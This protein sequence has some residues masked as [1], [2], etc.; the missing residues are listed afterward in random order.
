MKGLKQ[1]ISATGDKKTLWWFSVSGKITTLKA[2]LFWHQK[3]LN[4]HLSLFRNFCG[5]ICHRILTYSVVKFIKLC[6]YGLK[7]KKKLNILL[8]KVFIVY[9][10]CYRRFQRIAFSDNALVCTLVSEYFDSEISNRAIVVFKTQVYSLTTWDI[11]YI[12]RNS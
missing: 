4:T 2:F 6:I 5:V 3:N 12:N 1:L 8:L 7:K 9:L 11:K 10:F